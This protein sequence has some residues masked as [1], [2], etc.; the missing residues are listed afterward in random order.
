M[1]LGLRGCAELCGRSLRSRR[2]N[3]SIASG[4]YRELPAEDFAAIGALRSHPKLRQLGSEI[5][6]RMDVGAT[7]S[8]ELFW[9]EWDL[10]QTSFAALRQSGLKFSLSKLP[11][12]TYASHI[13]NQPISDLSILKGAPISELWLNSCKVMD[14]TPI[15][16]SPGARLGSSW[17][18]LDRPQALA[19]NAARRIV[20]TKKR[21]SAICP[22]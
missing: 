22:H 16:G 13:E 18:S 19:Q 17:Q 10:E 20:V 7:G 8:K 3:C 4:E 12:G 14:L 15:A 2:W 1:S 5:M 9:R 21:M 11:D 6:N